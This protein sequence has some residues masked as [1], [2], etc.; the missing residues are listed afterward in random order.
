MIWQGQ[1]NE[2]YMCFAITI[3]QQDWLFCLCLPIML[4]LRLKM[5]GFMNLLPRTGRTQA[6]RDYIAWN[7]TI[8]SSYWIYWWGSILSIISKMERY[9]LRFY[10]E[11]IQQLTGYPSNE[12]TSEIWIHWFWKPSCKESAD[13]SSKDAIR[14]MRMESIPIPH[15]S[16]SIASRLATEKSTGYSI[17]R[18][19]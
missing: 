17:Q 16:V 14:R 9:S 3:T 15:G 19:N 8:Y 12:F 1:V 18:S 11:G 10:R 13:C 2:F 4:Q 6:G 5:L 7:I